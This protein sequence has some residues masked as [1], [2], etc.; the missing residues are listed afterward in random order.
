MTSLSSQALGF[1]EAETPRGGCPGPGRET[2]GAFARFSPDIPPGQRPKVLRL[3]AQIRA[4]HRPGC[5]PILAVRVEGHADHDLTRERR[6]PGYEMRISRDRAERVA[7]ALRATLGRQLAGRVAFNIVAFGAQRLLVAN[8]ASEAQRARNRRV[9]VVAVPVAA[10]APPPPRPAVDPNVRWLRLLGSAVRPEN[11]VVDL[12]DGPEALAS[13]AQ[14]IRT[15]RIRGH[16]IYLLG[17]WLDLALPMDRLDA[18]STAGRL[19]T[20]AAA[21]GVQVRV[22]LWDQPGTKNTSE[23]N[24]VNSLRSGAAILDNSQVRFQ[25]GSQHQK[26]LVVKGSEGLVSF[27]GGVDINCDRVLAVPAGS[28]SGNVGQPLHDVHCRIEGPAAHDLL[29]T[30]ITR[31]FSN[32]AHA[33]LD[34]AKGTLLG[35]GE[36]VPS[37]RGNAFVRV[38]ETFTGRVARPGQPT[39]FRRE[40]TV[41]DIYLRVIAGARRFL[42]WEDQYLVNMCAAEALRSALPNIQ[43]LTIV[44]P[45]SEITDMPQIWRARKNFV[46]RIRSHPQGDK[47]RVFTLCDPVTLQPARHCYVHAKTLIA[48]DEAAIVGSANCNRRGW[49]SDAEVAACI[50]GGRSRPD[51]DVFAKRLRMRLWSEHLGVPPAAVRDPIASAGLWLAPTPRP[52]VRPLRRARPY[53]PNAGTDSWFNLRLPFDCIDPPEPS[54]SARCPTTSGA[55]LCRI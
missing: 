28:S 40:R 25:L 23:C 51:G 39:R 3:A 42:Y 18:N 30:F 12:V 24:F 4:S 52:P 13:M 45:A 22:M 35:L 33:P 6:E 46:D 9:E 49:E 36:P 26:V 5:R 31:W 20:Q 37:R 34:L 21:L 55:P 38:G 2:I 43:H 27:C 50:L 8:P 15:A 47:L 11:Q 48:D 17:W 54:P 41:Q 32:P 44:I 29:Q 7:R 16:Y 14:A 19:F 10:P 1:F 53:D